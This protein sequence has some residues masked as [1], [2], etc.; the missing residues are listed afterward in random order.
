MCEPRKSLE[1]LEM[2]NKAQALIMTAILVIGLIAFGIMSHYES[3]VYDYSNTTTWAVE[4]GD[5]LWDIAKE[6]SNNTHD[7]RKTIEI[8]K[9]L[10]GGL[11]SE[12]K[13]STII[14]VPLYDNMT[15]EKG[16][17]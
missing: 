7:V 2:R 13:P 3:E 16:G 12:L 6:Y 8:I 9:E 17:D 5:T 4:N 1:R 14:N 15:T 10:N 11:T